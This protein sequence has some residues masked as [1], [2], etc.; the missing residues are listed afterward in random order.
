MLKPIKKQQQPMPK[1]S[2]DTY[3]HIR[4]GHDISHRRGQQDTK[5]SEMADTLKLR[6]TIKVEEFVNCD[7]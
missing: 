7:V 5:L 1:G 4:S 6:G 2:L 3:I